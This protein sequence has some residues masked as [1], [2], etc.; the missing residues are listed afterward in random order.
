MVAMANYGGDERVV[1]RMNEDVQ[2]YDDYNCEDTHDLLMLMVV[3][4]GMMAYLMLLFD[5]SGGGDNDGAGDA[6]NGDDAADA[7]C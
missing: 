2:T 4:R 6:G 3:L 5:D 1:I 7:R